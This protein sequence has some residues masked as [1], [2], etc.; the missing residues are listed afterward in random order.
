LWNCLGSSNRIPLPACVYHEI[1][2]EFPSDSGLYKGF[3]EEDDDE[4]EEESENDEEQNDE[5]DL[6]GE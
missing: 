4:E 5:Q 1:R 2:K 6:Q 3:E